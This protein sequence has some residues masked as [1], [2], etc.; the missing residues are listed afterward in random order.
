MNFSM[1]KIDC[2]IGIIK[3]IIQSLNDENQ[4]KKNLYIITIFYLF[5]TF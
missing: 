5:Q 4:N 3:K 1:H 2:L